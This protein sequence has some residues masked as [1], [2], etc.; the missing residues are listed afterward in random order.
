MPSMP[1][2]PSL[3]RIFAER[4]YIK[5]MD[6]TGKIQIKIKLMYWHVR[7]IF[8]YLKKVLNFSCTIYSTCFFF[9]N[10]C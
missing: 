10:V 7:K 4:K 3:D 8:K 9:L 1:T 2:K 5:I 6:D